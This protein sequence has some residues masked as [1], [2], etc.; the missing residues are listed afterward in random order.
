MVHL[1]PAAKKYFLDKG[2]DQQNGVRPLKRL[3]QTTIEDFVSQKIIA[4]KLNTGD[5]VEIGVKNND[6][7]YKIVNEQKITKKV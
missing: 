3:I 7:S 5:I 2:Y 1:L 6:L 4:S